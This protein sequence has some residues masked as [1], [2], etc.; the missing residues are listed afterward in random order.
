V[1]AAQLEEQQGGAGWLFARGAFDK[2][3]QAYQLDQQEKAQHAEEARLERERS[4]FLAA[5]AATLEEDERRAAAAAGAAGAR[6][7]NARKQRE[8]ER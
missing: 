3:D 2:G 8:A 6:A 5:R 7:A 1:C 4:Q